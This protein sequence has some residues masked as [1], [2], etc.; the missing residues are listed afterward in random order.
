M[1]L[2]DEL[3]EFIKGEYKSLLAFSKVVGI[4]YPTLDSIFKR[5]LCNAGIGNVIKICR[6]LGI[7]ADGL[8]NGEII[9]YENSQMHFTPDERELI[10]KY[11]ALDER[12]K[13]A[14]D[15]TL[16]REYRYVQPLK[17]DLSVA[18]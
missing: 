16:D 17:E 1:T 8:A 11:R 13:Q 9:P 7:S 4:P 5:G 15:E 3:K 12:G 2:D 14:V 18:T 6:C 10:R